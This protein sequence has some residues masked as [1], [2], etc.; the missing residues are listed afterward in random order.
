[1]QEFNLLDNLLSNIEDRFLSLPDGPGDDCAIVK[2]IGDLL[3]SHDVL[4]ENVHFNLSWSSPEDVAWKSLATNE[5]DIA[6]MGGVPVGYTISLV[7]PKGY[8][9]FLNEFYK[10]INKYL[11][12]AEERGYPQKLLGG[13]LSS[14]KELSISVAVIGRVNDHPIKRSGAQPGNV[15]VISAQI[16]LAG[17][18]LKL[19]SGD[20]LGPE[21]SKEYQE[22]ARLKHRRPM[23]RTALGVSLSKLK[24][25]TAM[26]DISDGLFQDAIHI[27][28]AS[29]VSLKLDFDEIR[30]PDTPKYSELL[31][32]LSAGDDYELLFTLVDDKA[33]LDLKNIYP[34]IVKVGEVVSQEEDYILVENLN[35][36]ISLNSYLDKTEDKAKLGYQ[37]DF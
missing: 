24:I 16:G 32:R 35:G 28:K 13:D 19:F 14:G 31:R 15:L 29:K 3:C 22:L 34:E 8:S 21:F 25:A 1:M 6:S 12:D 18:G 9:N 23:A 2:G 5:S 7:V 26:I 33:Y 36:R 11:L 37:H 10:G 27:A 20:T 4:V 30:F 17:I